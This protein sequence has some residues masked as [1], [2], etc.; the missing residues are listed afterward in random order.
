M[1][2]LYAPAIPGR[3][4]KAAHPRTH[5]GMP[6]GDGGHPRGDGGGGKAGNAT[7]DGF[8]RGRGK[9][10][11]SGAGCQV[12]AA[13]PVS[14][15]VATQ[16]ILGHAVL[17]GPGALDRVTGSGMLQQYRLRGGRATREPRRLRDDQETDR[18]P[19]AAESLTRSCHDILLA[20]RLRLHRPLALNGTFTISTIAPPWP[21]GKCWHTSDS[22]LRRRRRR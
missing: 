2:E 8:R 21:D 17:T 16:L 15:D 5:P 1:R 10:G 22:A 13:S 4:R 12:G 11:T 14:A 7:S 3:T 18:P 20:Q 19:R 6:R 9:G